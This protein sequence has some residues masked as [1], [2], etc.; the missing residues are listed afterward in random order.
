M[1]NLVAP[2]EWQAIQAAAEELGI[3][4]ELLDVRREPRQHS[5]EC[6]RTKPT[7]C[8]SESTRLPKPTLMIVD[9]TAEQGL[10]TV[11]ISRDFVDMGGLLSYGPRLPGPVS[12]GCPAH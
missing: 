7:P 5:K 4:V 6:S 2:P 1:E 10:P 9:L 3:S 8:M 12:P 11:Y